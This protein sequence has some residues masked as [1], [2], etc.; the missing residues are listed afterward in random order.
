MTPVQKKG[1]QQYDNLCELMRAVSKHVNQLP[2]TEVDDVDLDVTD[3]NVTLKNLTGHGKCITMRTT[4][5]VTL[6]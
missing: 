5:S 6:S 4:Y 3:L 2:D 1:E